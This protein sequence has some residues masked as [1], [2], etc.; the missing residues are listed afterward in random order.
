MTVETI[1]DKDNINGHAEADK[2]KK[3]H[4]APVPHKELQ[5]TKKCWVWEK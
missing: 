4:E 2:K 1:M 3:A 5:A